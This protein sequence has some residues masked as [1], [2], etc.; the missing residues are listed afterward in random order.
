M[1]ILFF[2][3]S[4]CLFIIRFTEPEIKRTKYY[5]SIWTE[6][7][8]MLLTKMLDL[9]ST[10]NLLPMLKNKIKWERV[11]FFL[12]FHPPPSLKYFNLKLTQ[13]LHP[14]QH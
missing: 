9:D 10:S 14:L 4:N 13:N 12:L 8:I 1:H 2:T 7:L 6:N 11:V 5:D 3:F